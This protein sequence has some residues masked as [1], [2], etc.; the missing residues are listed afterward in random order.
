[1]P[2]VEKSIF[3]FFIVYNYSKFIKLKYSYNITF[4][5]NYININVKKGIGKMCMIF[6][7]LAKNKN[8]L[9]FQCSGFKN[10]SGKLFAERYGTVF[11]IVPDKHTLCKSE[12]TGELFEISIL[13]Q[14]FKKYTRID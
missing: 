11:E 12:K 9:K 6:K 10:E 14:A 3:K 13:N 8:S 1:M 2:Y 7:N 4:N 5:N